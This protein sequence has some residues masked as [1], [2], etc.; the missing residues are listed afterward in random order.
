[1]DRAMLLIFD[2][3]PGVVASQA[4][5]AAAN[6]RPG[7]VTLKNVKSSAPILL[8]AHLA[9]R[10]EISVANFIPSAVGYRHATHP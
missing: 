9:V 2:I 8:E 1:M 5:D 6:A 7:S 3:N 4:C 10:K